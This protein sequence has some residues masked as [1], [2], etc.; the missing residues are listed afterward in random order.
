MFL[1]GFSKVSDDSACIHT[2]F[3]ESIDVWVIVHTIEKRKI[4][5]HKPWDN[6]ALKE[7]TKRLKQ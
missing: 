3:K 5:Q 4:P 1:K 7:S 6:S 2:S